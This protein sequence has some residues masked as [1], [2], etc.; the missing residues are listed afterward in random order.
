MILTLMRINAKRCFLMF[1]MVTLMDPLFGKVPEH[2]KATK[3]IDFSEVSGMGY[4]QFGYRLFA[5]EERWLSVVQPGGISANNGTPYLRVSSGA[6]PVTLVHC[7]GLGF[8]LIA[9]DLAEYSTVAVPYYVRFRG[10]K[11]DGSAVEHTVYPDRIIDG[12]GP[13]EDFERIEFPPEWTSLAN[14]EVLDGSVALD[15]IEVRGLLLDDFDEEDDDPSTLELLSIVEEGEESN[16]WGVEKRIGNELLLR[17]SASSGNISYRMNYDID[18]QQLSEP[19]EFSSSEGGNS[20]TGERAW[21]SEGTLFWQ[22]GETVRELASVGDDGVTGIHYPNPGNGSVLFVNHW[23]QG[24]TYAAFMA[25]AEGVTL[26]FSSDTQLPDGGFP[27]SFPRELQFDGRNF[28]IT[29]SDNSVGKTYILSFDGGPLVLS[30]IGDIP[31]SDG[32]LAGGLELQSLNAQGAVYTGKSDSGETLRIVQMPD[33]SWTASGLPT[34]GNFERVTLPGAGYLLR[35]YGSTSRIDQGGLLSYG[36]IECHDLGPN[37]R[38]GIVATTLNG[39]RHLMIR[40]GRVI[41]GFG[42]IV[43]VD[44]TA[45]VSEGWFYGTARS[46]EGRVGLFRSK[47]PDDEPKPHTGEFLFGSDGTL[48]LEVGGLTHGRR[49]RMESSVDLDGVWI[50]SSSF[51]AG[52]PRRS[53]FCDFRLQDCGFFRLVEEL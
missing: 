12:D 37:N 3:V 31:D 2:L 29:R 43:R 7:D 39:D 22:L 33:G 15:N 6:T 53:V 26:L 36:P 21:V 24:E 16:T 45:L 25:D 23:Y 42:K 17:R 51:R 4:T 38:I 35:H 5:P 52:G 34:P 50:T 1:A 28:A 10:T 44:R 41:S 11:T 48:R 9:L 19:T 14:V 32:R 47:L 8:D 40:E 20:S 46:S 49:Y 30:P 13:L 27:Y 18:G